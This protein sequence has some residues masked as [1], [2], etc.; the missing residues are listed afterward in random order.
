MTW[1]LLQPTTSKCQQEAF[2][3]LVN[4]CS[5][6]KHQKNVTLPSCSCFTMLTLSEKLETKLFSMVG[7]SAYIKVFLFSSSWFPYCTD[8]NWNQMWLQHIVIHLNLCAMPVNMAVLQSLYDLWYIY[9]FYSILFIFLFYFIITIMLMT[10][11]NIWRLE[12]KIK[13]RMKCCFEF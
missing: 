6:I 3:H 8:I 1:L 13:R 12:R 7:N 5:G 4:T 9:I 2:I 11:Y 10:L